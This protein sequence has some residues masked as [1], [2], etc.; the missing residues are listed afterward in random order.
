MDQE[1]H[2]LGAA[3][4]LGAMGPVDDAGDHQLLAELVGWGVAE[5][6]EQQGELLVG[7]RK[8]L[9]LSLEAVAQHLRDDGANIRSVLW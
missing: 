1:V 6:G 2:A 7:L 5:R 8:W 9:G 3:L 4:V